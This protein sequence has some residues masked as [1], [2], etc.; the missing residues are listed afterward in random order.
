M[1]DNEVELFMVSSVRQK[2]QESCANF[3]KLKSTTHISEI[4][5]TKPVQY[6]TSMIELN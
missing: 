4:F 1:T 6:Y 2:P 5:I 3:F